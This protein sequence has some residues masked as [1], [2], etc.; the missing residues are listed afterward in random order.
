[1][2]TQN[3]SAKSSVRG[4]VKH[5]CFT[6]IELLVVIAIIAIL[7]SILMP[8][9][10]QARERAKTSG[11]NNNLK[12]FGN[13]CMMYADNY[14][15]VMFAAQNPARGFGTSGNHPWLRIDANPFYFG[16]KVPWNTFLKTVLCPA[17]TNPYE[18]GGTENYPVK[19]SYGFGGSYNPTDKTRGIS[20]KMLAKIQNPSA[21]LMM[22]DTAHN[23]TYNKPYCI[24]WDGSGN[25][26]YRHHF[27]GVALLEA[28][29]IRHNATPNVLYADGH[30]ASC[31]NA[32][33]FGGSY[34]GQM[35]WKTFW[36]YKL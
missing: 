1:M 2:S 6:L 11:C 29:R 18:N 21:V 19:S 27:Y 12:T 28:N 7:A 14:N 17:D 34:T 20:S 3:T 16:C 8:A 25:A 15:G 24:T 26:I 33:Y 32:V 36:Q 31:Y 9:L 23:E 22:A 35:Y 4:Q 13:W 10:S 30:V 5:S